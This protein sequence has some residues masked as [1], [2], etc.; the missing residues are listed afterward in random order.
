MVADRPRFLDGPCATPLYT[1][2]GRVA[3]N[4]EPVDACWSANSMSTNGQQHSFSPEALQPRVPGSDH[5]AA[6]SWR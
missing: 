1:P 3:G 6:G 2:P 5:P 4:A